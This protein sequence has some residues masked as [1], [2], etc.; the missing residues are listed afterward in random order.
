MEKPVK[1]FERFR[2]KQT[3]NFMTSKCLPYL[4]GFRKNHNS[5]HSLLKMI[6]VWKKYLDKGNLVGV[7]LMD[8]LKAFDTISDSLLLAKLEAYGI[9]LTSLEFLQSYL[10]KRFK[11]TAMNGPFRSWIDIIA[12]VPKGSNWEHCCL[13]FS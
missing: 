9:S 5:Q 6:E 11:R 4:C 12:R 3:D 1:I 10:C 8:L 13:K 2:Y 7:T